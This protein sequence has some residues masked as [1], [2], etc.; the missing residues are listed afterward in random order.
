MNIRESLLNN[1]KKLA[2]L[3]L[4]KGTSGNASIRT[5]KGFLVTPSGMAIEQLSP[6]NM[7][8][9]NMT[10]QAISAGKPS[11]EWRFHRDIYQARPE[12]HAI[13]HTH[14][15]FATSLSCLRQNIPPFHYMI[16]VAGGKN[17]RCAEYALFGTQDLS[18]AAIVALQDRKACLLANHGM[19]AL[20]KTLD[21]A[22]NVAV[23]IETLCEQYWRA[24]QVGQPKILSDQEMTE[25]FEQFKDYGNWNK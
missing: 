25:V 1:F 6:A 8:E 19:I 14:S 9:I 11:S 21:Q 23:E 7:V 22:V 5:D 16:A 12:V 3:G 20:G 13:V 18:D 17:I 24:L 10:G 15:M 4:N 2:E